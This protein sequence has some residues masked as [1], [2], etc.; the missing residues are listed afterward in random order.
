MNENP[1][2]DVDILNYFHSLNTFAHRL[3]YGGITL[4][5]KYFSLTK[6]KTEYRFD[7]LDELSV[8]LCE[9]KFE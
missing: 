7:K 3:G 8:F 4:T 6:N 2:T 5:K 1:R 9:K